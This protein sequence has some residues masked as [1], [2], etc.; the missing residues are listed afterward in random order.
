MTG[1]GVAPSLNAQRPAGGP[2]WHGSLCLQ[3]PPRGTSDWAEGWI[4]RLLLNLSCVHVGVLISPSWDGGGSRGDVFVG[5][6]HFPSYP[7]SS[8]KSMWVL[9]V[10]FS[11]KSC[12]SFLFSFHSLC[13]SVALCTFLLWSHVFLKNKNHFNFLGK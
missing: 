3:R 4:G 6:K 13:L 2:R 7:L 5:P 8:V 12:L 10:L 9:M 1:L 11:F